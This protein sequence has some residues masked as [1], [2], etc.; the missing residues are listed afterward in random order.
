M[1]KP[2]MSAVAVLI[3]ST[4]LFAQPH[5]NLNTTAG[6]HP[7]DSS[8]AFTFVSG[9]G[10]GL[11]QYCVTG[12]GNIAQFSAVGGNG[13]PTEFLSTFGPAIEGYGLCAANALIPYWDYAQ[14]DSGNWNTATAVLTNPNTVVITRTTADGVWKLVQTITQLKGTRTSY[15]AAKITVAIT[16]LS[17]TD[18][19]II[20]NRHAHIEAGATLNDYDV[21]QTTAFGMVPGGSGLSSTASF[22]TTAFDFSIGFVMTAPGGPGPNPCESFPIQGGQQAFFQGDGAAEQ[23]FDLD[24]GPGKTKTVTV[25]YR[26]I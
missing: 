20:F 11:T 26:P 7:P 3:F 19:V 4:L 8:C 23:V 21:T 2:W 10:H 17:T 22:V 9:T 24:I 15:G 16:N 5:P 12:N 13:L 1:L 14:N 6:V 18:T 25:T